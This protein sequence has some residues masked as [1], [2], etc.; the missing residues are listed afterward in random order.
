MAAG[1]AL[2]AAGRAVAQS[3]PAKPV[4]LV[5]PFA[6]GGGYDILARAVGARMQTALGQPIVVENR[7]GAAGA[8]GAAAVARS[9]PDGYTVLLG[10]AGSQVVVPLTTALTGSGLRPWS[11][12]L[13]ST[14][15]TLEAS[16]DTDIYI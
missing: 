16:T 9:A 6:A 14:E 2:L 3:W 11:S 5:V 4:K 7:G 12:T 10:S 8:L 1:A 15:L 13:Y